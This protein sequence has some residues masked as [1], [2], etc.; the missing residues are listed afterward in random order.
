MALT[1]IERY[2]R[3][4]SEDHMMDAIRQAVAFKGGKSWHLNDARTSPELEDLPDLI[5]VCDE[6]VGLLE[7]K[8]QTRAV[9]AGQQEV[10]GML[11]CAKRVVAGVVRPMPRVGELAYDDVIRWLATI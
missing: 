1:S 7:L 10:A 4:P 5:I 11:R 2:Q 9:T 3:L 8:S 6:W